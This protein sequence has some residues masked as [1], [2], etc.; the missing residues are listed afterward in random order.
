[1]VNN[2]FLNKA[3]SLDEKKAELLK[4]LEALEK[5]QSVGA[6]MNFQ[7]L[8]EEFVRLRKGCLAGVIA[9]FV[10]LLLLGLVMIWL[11]SL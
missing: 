8:S 1:M 9:S 2:P 3:P 7:L 10:N 4:Q 11:T 6:D 5:P